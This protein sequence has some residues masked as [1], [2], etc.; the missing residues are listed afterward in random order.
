MK[1][2]TKMNK[3]KSI[4]SMLTGWVNLTNDDG[5]V[6]AQLNAGELPGTSSLVELVTKIAEAYECRVSVEKA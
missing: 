1:K 3:T 5:I 6:I 2:G 4:E